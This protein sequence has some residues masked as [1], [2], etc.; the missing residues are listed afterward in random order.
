MKRLIKLILLHSL[1]LNSLIVS[2]KESVQVALTSVQPPFVFD[3]GFNSGLIRDL[4]TEMNRA[5]DKFEFVLD[6]YPP[7]RIVKDHERLHV[8]L[9]AFNDLQWGWESQGGKGSLSLTHGRDVFFKFTDVVSTN[10]KK[11][12]TIA[13]VR[14]FHYKFAGFNLSNLERNP[15]VSLLEN[16]PRVIEFLSYGRADKGVSSEAYLSW[17]ALS[18]PRLFERITMLEVDH[19]YTRRFIAMPDSVISIEELNK[20]LMELDSTGLL[21]RIFSRYG[22][23]PPSLD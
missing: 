15:L 7:S 3:D 5:Q 1:L 21:K 23:P 22:Q 20:L 16:E 13:A 4:I 19:T 9:I 6:L 14:G 12:E 2:A 11:R 8:D 10:S 17:L 18:K